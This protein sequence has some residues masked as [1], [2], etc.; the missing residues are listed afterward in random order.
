MDSLT[1]Y[2]TIPKSIRKVINP[3][4]QTNNYLGLITDSSKYAYIIYDSHNKLCEIVDMHG[5]YLEQ[6]IRVLQNSHIPSDTTIF[7][8]IPIQ[9][10]TIVEDIEEYVKTGFSDPYIYKDTNLCMCK[11]NSNKKH[12]PD[13]IEQVKYVLTQFLLVEKQ[14][15]CT[16]TLSLSQNTVKYLKN[17]TKSGMSK[18]SDGTFTQK[19]IAGALEVTNTT[20]DMVHIVDY[21]PDSIILGGEEGVSIVPSLYNFHSHPKEAYDKYQ[22]ILA[23]PSPQDYIGF[24]MA[25][26]EDRTICHLVIS[27]EGIYIISLT[28]QWFDKPM[29]MDKKFSNF[30]KNNYDPPCDGRSIDTY[31]LYINSM[32]Y[33]DAPPI[34]EVQYLSWI[35]ARNPFTVTFS[36]KD[37]NC[38]PRK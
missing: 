11:L 7:G 22:V 31:L 6:V 20:P 3:P 26:I 16:V 21:I 36:R 5:R 38:S 23:W 34:I 25:V 27:I 32:K 2:S 29:H 1:E 14:S 28:S 35:D 4:P 18:N 10:P 17:T 30:I 9:S 12:P 33:N 15:T 13:A 19:E 37:S 24:I 8:S